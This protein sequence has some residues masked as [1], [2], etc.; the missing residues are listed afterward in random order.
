MNPKQLMQLPED[1][2]RG[3]IIVTLYGNEKIRIENFKGISSYTAEEIRI[4][5]RNAMFKI[6]G[7]KLEIHSFQKDEMEIT[8]CIEK[9]EYDQR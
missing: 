4:L 1:C 2:L 6:Y 5:T 7:K 9:I 8:G 3:N